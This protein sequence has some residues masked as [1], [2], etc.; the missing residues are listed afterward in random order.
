MT[1]RLYLTHT[2]T[3]TRQTHTARIY[4]IQLRPLNQ[5]LFFQDMK[6]NVFFFPPSERQALKSRWFNKS[7]RSR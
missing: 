1:E 2:H 4:K 7:L 3:S 6:R 5:N